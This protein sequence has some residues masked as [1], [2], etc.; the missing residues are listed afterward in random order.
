MFI[1][2]KDI[3]STQLQIITALFYNTRATRQELSELTDIPMSTL[4]DNLDILKK[5]RIVK[6]ETEKRKKRGRPKVYWK[7]INIGQSKVY[8]I[9]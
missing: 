1:S 8:V 3:T 4:Y 5:R 9:E 2:T 6:R 7:L